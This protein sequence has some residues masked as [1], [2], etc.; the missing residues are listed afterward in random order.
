VCRQAKRKLADLLSADNDQPESNAMSRREPYRFALYGRSGSGKTCVLAT[1][2]LGAV[3][4][5]GGLTCTRVPVAIPKP[6]Q[7]EDSLQDWDTQELA[8]EPVNWT[9]AE[10][11]A[12]GLHAGTDWIDQAAAAL[13][14][15]ER[16]APN[17]PLDGPPWMVD[18][19]IGS[20]E[21]G[22]VPVRTIDYAGELIDP[23]DAHSP[24]SMSNAL[25][26]CLQEFDG[27]IILVEAPRLD[28]QDEAA[29]GEIRR[30]QQA[31][32]VLQ[33]AQQEAGESAATTPV[34][35]MFSKW[36]RRL[37]GEGVSSPE[38]LQTSLQAFLERHPAYDALVKT[39]QNTLTDQQ[40]HDDLPETS[41][42]LQFGNCTVFP[43]SAFGKAENREGE[44]FPAEG[45]DPFGLLDPFVWLADRRDA[46]DA[47]NLRDEWNALRSE[48][49]GLHWRFWRYRDLSRRAGNRV[50]R[51][52]KKSAAAQAT[53]EIRRWAIRRFA[54]SGTV[55]LAV[56]V[57]IANLMY[58]GVRRGQFQARVAE[59]QNSQ[60]SEPRLLQVSTW[61]DDYRLSWNGLLVAPS[62]GKAEEHVGRIVEEIDRRYWQ[63]VEVA[64]DLDGKRQAANEYL[65]RLPNGHHVTAARQI[66]QEWIEQDRQSRMDS[67]HDDNER[68]LADREQGGERALKSDRETEIKTALNEIGE[69][70]P[71]PD[72][73]LPEQLG[74]RLT[75]KGRLASRLGE[76]QAEKDWESCVDHH[77]KALD[78]PNFELAAQL[79]SKRQPRD[80]H[81]RTLVEGFPDEVLNRLRPK[82]EK[83]NKE[84]NFLMADQLA[85]KAVDSLK[86]LETALRPTHA[87]LADH[88]LSGQR[89]LRPIRKEVNTQHDRHLYERIRANK[90]QLEYC[91]QYLERAPLKAM[92]S[93]VERYQQY[94]EDI[95]KP[96]NL[97]I[98]VRLLW[99][100][101]Y[102][103]WI[104]SDGHVLEVT[105]DD[106]PALQEQKLRS[107]PGKLSGEVDRIQLDKRRL[108]ES[109]RVQATLSRPGKLFGQYESFSGTRTIRLSELQNGEQTIRL[110]GAKGAKYEHEL[111]L[112]IVAGMPSEPNLPVWNAP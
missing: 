99:H 56:L 7:Q 4:H 5:P 75:L 93:E 69:E 21:R 35:I 61:F 23:D 53:R 47:A 107:D 104:N 9:A 19:H 103:A 97:S 94:R 37:P 25:K 6:A 95:Q 89:D 22:Q 82:I 77:R 34:A 8:V 31:F 26:R 10:R 74:R 68:W 101:N 12:A 92:Q 108:S 87:E 39:I 57:S 54:L 16:P 44:D 70:F 85:H 20:P 3:G 18:F 106:R 72:D 58:G 33:Q 109:V 67:R 59:S 50:E 28:Q 49:N 105:I 80:P 90:N 78:V 110:K 112:Q 88:M 36:D 102:G 66:I 63:P 24:T 15:G 81:W 64:Q 48:W 91:Q 1:L 41:S 76:I 111:R 51:M 98:S 40:A 46:L 43:A 84:R 38:R 2:S 45:S 60:T 100:Q 83:F 42:G 17:A 86:H 29:I 11:E 71:H 27:F 62:P 30:L 55:W 96:L 32:A 14:K 73:A 52:S 65:E 79:L 13:Q